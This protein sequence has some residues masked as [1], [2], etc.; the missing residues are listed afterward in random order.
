MNAPVASENDLRLVADLVRSESGIQIKESNSYLIET[1]LGPLLEELSVSSYQQLCQRSR[2]D[3]RVLNRVIDEI[4]TSETLF[5]RDKTPFD[6]LKFKL[7]PDFMDKTAGRAERLSIWCAACSTGQEVYSV[8]LACAEVLSPAE[9]ARVQIIGTDISDQSIRR[10]SSGVYSQFEVERGFPVDQRERYLERDGDRWRV[11]ENLRS[12]VSFR[13]M[14]LLEG[15]E[16]LVKFDVVF[17]R[18]VAIYFDAATNR[19]IFERIALQLKPDGSLVIGA[20]ESLRD[21]NLV[22]ERQEYMNSVFYKR[23]Y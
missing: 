1:R 22:F 23:R 19:D 20:S 21:L 7:I 17:C 12:I 11:R 3:P 10:A 18:N 14:N 4:S 6:C 2:M 16:K 9:L 8:A 5:F 15:Y 13:H